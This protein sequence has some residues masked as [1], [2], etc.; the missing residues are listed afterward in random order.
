MAVTYPTKLGTAIANTIFGTTAVA[1]NDLSSQIIENF[2][3]T[4]T[5]EKL[6]VKGNNGAIVGVWY[7]NQTQNGT[8]SVLKL[9]TGGI[10]ADEISET[11]TIPLN[12][13]TAVVVLEQISEQRVQ[14]DVVKLTYTWTYFPG[15]T[16]S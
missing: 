4:T 15:V 6:E 11:M 14:N 12:G 1:A 13:T 8:F 10:T 5:S 2:S 16:L 3:V 7:F 9:S